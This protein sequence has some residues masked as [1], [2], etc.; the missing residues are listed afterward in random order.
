MSKFVGTDFRV[1]VSVLL[2]VAVGCGDRG[3]S[4]P[5]PTP[6]REAERDASVKIDPASPERAA[7][8]RL[9][10][11]S[12]IR[13]MIA[14]GDDV[15]AMQTVQSHLLRHP[16]DANA[17]VLASGLF[18]RQGQVDDAV[19]MLDSAAELS[20]DGGWKWRKRAASMLADAG[21]W[22]ESIE[23]LEV[24]L[25][26]RPEL[27]DVRHELVSVL[28]QRGFRFDANEHVRLLCRQGNA[29]LDELRG[30]IFPAR[31]FTGL[32]EKPRVEDVE[33]HRVLGEMNVARAMHG[34]GDVKDASQVLRASRLLAERHPAAMA[35]YGQLLIESQQFNEF[36]KWLGEVDQASHRYP[37][38]WLALGS[39]A[40]WQRKFDLAVGQFAQA[41]LREPG[42][43]AAID[44]MSQALSA[45][46]HLVEHERFRQ[47]GV[48]IDRL[49]RVTRK[50]LTGKADP[51]AIDEISKLLNE[52]GR[53][54][55]ALGWYRLAVENMGSPAGGMRQLDQAL[56]MA[57]DDAF[58]RNRLATVLCDL[59]LNRFPGE[60]DGAALK[61][62]GAIAT[63]S[64]AAPP[65]G[66]PIDPVF[67][68]VA[69]QAGLEFTYYNAPQQRPRELRL[70]E[71]F[72]AGVACIDYD[73]DG[74][75]DFYLGQA[76]SE[77]PH[78]RGTRPNMLARSLGD[79]FVGV[80]NVASCDDRGYTCGI[81][82]GDWN[83]DGFPDLVIANVMGNTLLINRGDGTFAPQAG[84][85][86]WGEPLYTTSLAIGDVD[87]DHLPDLVEV[88]Y[89]DD[90]SVFDPIQYKA[91]GTP[92]R[93]P[94]PLDF[95]PGRDRLFLSVG[96]GTMAGQWIDESG[97]VAPGTGLGVILA[98]L[99][100]D[101]GNEILIVN[102]HLANHLWQRRVV[103]D[104]RTNV[105]QDTAAAKG[106]AFGARGTPLGCM[107]I[108]VGDFDQNGRP[109]LHVTNFEREWNNQFMQDESGFFD[110]L[111]IAFGLDQPTYK[112]LG[113]GVQAFDYDN[114]TRDDLVIGNGHVEDYSAEGRAFEMP[115]L[116]F[117]MEQT[118]FVAKDV[119]GDP[120]YWNAG[121]LSRALASCD[122]NND[123]RIDFIVTDLIEPVA[124]LENRTQTP[125]HWM[126]LQL[127]GTTAERDAIGAT[128]Q[129]D[130]G[131]QTLT[132]VVQS[133]DG[134][135]CRNQAIVSFGLGEHEAVERLEIRWPDGEVQRFAGL[136]AD[137]RLVIVQAQ[138]DAFELGR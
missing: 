10:N 35:F 55:E 36:H 47:R 76:S 7:E 80:T 62:A 53:P 67:V 132:K 73:L 123:G 28:N 92:V 56:A 27:D 134:Y 57:D 89:V 30:L 109:D 43:L 127:V 116:V 46:G 107:G 64:L 50:L 65:A 60:A 61:T 124:L 94:A 114:N 34:E 95:R 121:H 59:D 24:L 13:R 137:R 115:T 2:S 68:N 12:K 8:S 103:G 40:M 19:A 4:T 125:H 22:Q 25:R 99:D 126:Q 129:L 101:L 120:G 71:Q 29:T 74:N 15:G 14:S 130:I 131:G 133:G 90:A 5:T 98:D 79:R 113:F 49:M 81:T 39:W 112:M 69:S 97:Q 104:G 1:V 51:V 54:V 33:Q 84:D 9:A 20:T 16:E 3:S 11:L 21:R 78:G 32:A 138:N 105:W 26:E 88:N 18:N 106:V 117:A 23:R 45:G 136:A 86:V 82:A 44:R 41:I 102:D 48:L 87:G 108:A 38:Y 77:P 31:S 122:W 52:S 17:M 63:P 72:G 93:L 58:Q 83:Q 118:R 70:F 111:V 37:A 6:T 75:V 66:Q 128:V 85:S 96:D 119:A 100:G 110:D 42:D 135:L 91:N